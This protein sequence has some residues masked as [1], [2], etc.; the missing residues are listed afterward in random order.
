MKR[1]GMWA[2]GLAAMLVWI[3]L[4]AAKDANERPKQPSAPHLP[5][6]VKV[7]RDF[8]YVENG[9][10]RNRLDLY[11]PEKAAAKLPLVVWIHGGGWKAGSKENCPGVSMVTRG[12]ALASINY[13]LS[14]HAPFPAQIQDCKAAIR[15]L[16][17]NAQQYHLDADHIGVWG[18]SAGGHLVALLGTT[19][20][21]KELEGSGHLDQ[22]SRVQCVVDFFGPTDFVGW[23]PEFNKAVYEMIA[24]LLGG[25]VL[26]NKEKARQASPVTY[27]S[28]SAAPFLIMHGDQDKL[29]PLAQ[30][31]VLAAALKKAGAEV[32]LQVIQ[33]AGHGGPAF[34]TPENLKQID[35]F[36]AKHLGKEM[37]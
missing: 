29:V 15:W 13:R 4:A 2:I 35:D 21:V 19:G 16:R 7:L 36:F 11:L 5:K 6:G 3:N 18:G 17:A 24:H 25:P 1:A 26:E 22:S 12:Y 8:P 33:G 27:V 32:T 34:S 20:N 9:H 37:P 10:E 30:S 31:Q 23:D 28:K 14:Q